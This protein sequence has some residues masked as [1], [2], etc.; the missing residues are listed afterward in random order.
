[1]KREKVL[2]AVG[3][4]WGD[5]LNICPILKW[6]HDRGNDVWFSVPQAF[7]SIFDWISYAQPFLPRVDRQHA[8]RAISAAGERQFDRTICFH[9]ANFFTDRQTDHWNMEMWR[10]GG[11]LAHFHDPT[12]PL[13]LDKP[14]PSPSL[15][16]AAAGKIVVNV[17]HAR[18][19]PLEMGFNLL[20]RIEHA[21]PGWVL[22]VGPIRLGHCLEMLAVLR[23]ARLIV[24]ID[25]SLLH[26]GAGVDTPMVALVLTGRYCGPITTGNAWR[27]SMP[28]WCAAMLSYTVVRTCP[29]ILIETIARLAGI[30]AATA[31][32][33]IR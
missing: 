29:E 11:C 6:E 23:A 7:E 19:S 20:R 17:T 8:P 25:T 30:P 21:F 14:H 33:S 27:G 9:P 18:T 24:T 15:A 2:A 26:M 5:I 13:V 10:H 1:M 12:W 22:D 32:R 31:S 3:G 16:A 4:H 28:R